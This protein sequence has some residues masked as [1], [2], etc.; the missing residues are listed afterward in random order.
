MLCIRFIIA[1]RLT[2][3]SWSV[4]TKTKVSVGLCGSV[5]NEKKLV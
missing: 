5:A 2:V 3:L 1:E 4:S